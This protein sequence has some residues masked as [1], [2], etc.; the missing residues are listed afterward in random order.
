MMLVLSNAGSEIG[1]KEERIQVRSSGRVIREIRLQDLEG[2]LA[3]VTTT[4]TGSAIRKLLGRGIDIVFLKNSGRLA[5]RLTGPFAANSALRIHQIQ[6]MDDRS[7]A[8]EMARRFVVAKLENQR[9]N[10]LRIRRK[11]RIEELGTAARRIR[12]LSRS[13]AKAADI[14]ELRGM[15]GA[16]AAAYFEVFG[17]LITNEVFAF[18]GRNRRPPRDP[19]NACL[20]FGY[21]LL[22]SIIEGEIAAA[23]LDPMIGYLHQPAYSRPSLALDLLE[24]YRAPIVDVLTL[25]LINRRTLSPADFGPPRQQ[26]TVDIPPWLEMDEEQE[27]PPGIH[28]APSGRPIFLKAFFQ[29]LRSQVVDLERGDTITYHERIRRSCRMAAKAI[30]DGNADLYRGFK[31]VVT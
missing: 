13:A 14:D 12:I 2:I 20:S 19:I 3:P 4:I 8:L 16:G 24:E 21:T 9:S 25:T 23:G 18:S 28:L 6:R 17:H 7:F 10:L 31:A 27:T 15:E 30:S 1:I 26:E 22:G 5:G 29:R 11:R